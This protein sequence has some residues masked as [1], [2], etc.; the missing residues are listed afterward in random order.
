VT[1]NNNGQVDG[2]VF[3]NVMGLFAT[4]VTVLTTMANGQPHAMTANA[5]TSVSLDPL[6]VLICVQKKAH[7]ADSLQ[8]AGQF[9]G[10]SALCVKR[11]R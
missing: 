2:R 3:R 6:L 8:Q 7:M 1:T 10:S 11:S 9:S 5:L 4:G